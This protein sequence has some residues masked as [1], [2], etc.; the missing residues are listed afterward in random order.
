MTDTGHP[1]PSIGSR[2][3][4]ILGIVSLLMVVVIWV[5]S[6]FVMNVSDSGGKVTMKFIVYTDCSDNGILEHLWRTVSDNLCEYGILFII[7][8]P[9][10]PKTQVQKQGL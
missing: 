9:L 7:L 6:S 4:Y 10:S 1:V 3:R 2:R 5:S 8:A